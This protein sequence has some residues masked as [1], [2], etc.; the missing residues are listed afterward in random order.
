M[1][2]KQIQ[3]VLS[4]LPA[5]QRAC[6]IMCRRDHMSYDEIAQHLRIGRHDVQDAIAS[7][8]VALAEANRSDR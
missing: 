3:A 1:M 5:R 7:A 6:L 2:P 8:L 4:T